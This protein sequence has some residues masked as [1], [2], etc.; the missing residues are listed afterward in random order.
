VSLI[1]NH[2]EIPPPMHFGEGLQIENTLLHRL[3]SL[4]NES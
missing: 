1:Q 2:Q 3:Q 4:D